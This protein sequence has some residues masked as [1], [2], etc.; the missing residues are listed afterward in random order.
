MTPIFDPGLQPER[1]L[2]A[3]RRT[4]LSLT[5]AGLVG[6]RMLPE[7]LGAWSLL[8]PLLVL[9]TSLA[10][11]VIAERRARRVYADLKAELPP[12]TAGPALLILSIAVTICALAAIWWIVI[13]GLDARTSLAPQTST[14]REFL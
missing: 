14:G 6:L 1:T 8:A 12:P 7:R 5:T 11:N 2:L 10:L 4:L 9:A 13:L 3:W